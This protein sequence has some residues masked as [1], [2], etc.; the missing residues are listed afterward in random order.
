MLQVS[1]GKG[2]SET[3]AKV[4]AIMEGI[5][6]F[7]SENPRPERLERRCAADLRSR[8]CELMHPSASR[9]NHNTYYSDRFMCDW[10]EGMDLLTGTPVWAPASA[11]YFFMEPSLQSTTTNGLASGNHIDEATLHALYELIERDSV[12][13][14]CLSTVGCV[15]MA[16]LSTSGR[17]RS[18][19]RSFAGS[20]TGWTRT[21]RR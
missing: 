18:M 1:T 13:R 3:A 8:E 10:T 20:S 21:A 2:I 9:D 5:E 15:L 11:I 6:L 4:S 16:T 14:F 19:H 12:S 17:I 7:H